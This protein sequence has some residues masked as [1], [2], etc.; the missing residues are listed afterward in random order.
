[1]E[2]VLFGYVGPLCSKIQLCGNF[3]AYKKITL[4]CEVLSQV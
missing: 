3:I 2:Y 4:Q 1:M